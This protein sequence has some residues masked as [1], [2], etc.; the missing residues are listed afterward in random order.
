MLL[1]RKFDELQR[2]CGA[3]AEEPLT[4]NDEVL[5]RPELRALLDDVG[6]LPDLCDPSLLERAASLWIG[7][8]GTRTPLRHDTQM[9]LQ[10][11]IAG[12]KRLYL[13]PAEEPF[14]SCE[15]LERIAVFDLE[16]DIPYHSWFDEY[17]LTYDLEPGQMVADGWL[18][19]VQV[20]GGLGDRAVRGD[21]RKDPQP[22]D[23]QH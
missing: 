9:L 8:A 20:L 23:I 4:V 15:L 2:R 3:P 6:P 5:R 11:Q 13:Y 10:T 12:R 14:I 19:V 17:A 21:R 22:H 16:I 18:G 1:P 7:P